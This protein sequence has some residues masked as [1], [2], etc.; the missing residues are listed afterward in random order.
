MRVGGKYKLD[1]CTGGENLQV[2]KGHLL[3][4]SGYQ[5][6]IAEILRVISLFA[7]AIGTR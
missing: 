6:H 7:P 3:P 5:A 4:V 1:F 2:V